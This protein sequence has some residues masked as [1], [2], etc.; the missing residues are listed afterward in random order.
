[1]A[2]SA[3]EKSETALVKLKADQ[4]EL[5]R[6][7]KLEERRRDDAIQR[8]NAPIKKRIGEAGFEHEILRGLTA[9]ELKDWFAKAVDRLSH[10]SETEPGNDTPERLP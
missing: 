5:A 10:S 2:Q 9:S 1:M 4:V 6:R 7:V 3:R 8:E